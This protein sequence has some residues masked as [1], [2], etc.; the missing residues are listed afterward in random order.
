MFSPV[1][2]KCKQERTIY[3]VTVSHFIPEKGKEQTNTYI[4]LAATTFYQCHQNHKTIFKD[5][6]I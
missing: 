2:G 1:Q 6:T 5:K 4:G 3:Q